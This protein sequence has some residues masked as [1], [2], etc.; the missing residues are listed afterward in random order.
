[1]F[2]LTLKHIIVVPITLL[3]I[4]EYIILK[5]KEGSNTIKSHIPSS[6]IKREK[7]T[8]TLLNIYERHSR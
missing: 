1:M 3:Q 5:G 8:H 4:L 2:Y 7:N 6:K